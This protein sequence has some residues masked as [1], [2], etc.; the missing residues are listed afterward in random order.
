MG[1][2]R[3]D[4]LGPRGP[5]RGGPEA[6][7]NVPHPPPQ[8]WG[9]PD[10]GSA[11]PPAP[12]TVRAVTAG[13]CTQPGKLGSG[14]LS[15]PACHPRRPW[16]GGAGM[17]LQPAPGRNASPGH[18]C[19]FPACTSLFCVPLSGRM[20]HHHATDPE[21]RAVESQADRKASEVTLGL[22]PNPGPAASAHL[23]AQMIGMRWVA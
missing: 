1:G 7:A 6:H 19:P 4:P 17:P 20:G 12:P 2:H 18:R 3:P 5:A 22:L 15:L 21:F 8:A 16:V 10:K 13:G 14:H 9:T 11:A 23:V